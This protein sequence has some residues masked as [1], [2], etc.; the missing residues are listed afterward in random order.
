MGSGKNTVDYEKTDVETGKVVNVGVIVGIVAVVASVAV[1]GL[2]N[3]FSDMAQ[4]AD[5]PVPPMGRHEQGRLPP[6]PRLQVNPF[7]DV[8]DLVVEDKAALAA[9]AWVD[10]KAGIA[11][12]PIDDAMRIVAQKGLPRWPR[13][14][15]SPA[16]AA[17]PASP[18]VPTPPP[19]PPPTP[20]TE[21]RP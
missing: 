2:L 15:A 17:S 6:E 7:Q 8:R 5:P 10:E 1:L 16:P 12:I 14:L 19:T 13:V 9:S 21:P 20:R 4:K 3:L 18:A 11:R